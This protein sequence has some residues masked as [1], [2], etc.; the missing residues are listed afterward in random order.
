VPPATGTAR[1]D[2][3]TLDFPY[4]VGAFHDTFVY[5]RATDTWT[6]RLDAADG[7]GGWKRFAEYRVARR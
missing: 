3:L 6:I 5:D 4:P 7:G 1:G 2:T